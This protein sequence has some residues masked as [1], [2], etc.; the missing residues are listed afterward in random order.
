MNTTTTFDPP[1]SWFTTATAWLDERGKLAWIAAM[2]LGFVFLWPVGLAILFYMIWSKRMFG[3]H[4]CRDRQFRKRGFAWT[5]ATGNSA[6]DRYRDDT[7]KRLMD[8]QAA[9]VAFLER[10][11]NAKDQ[12]EFD[13]FMEER[14]RDVT[15]GNDA[16]DD[17]NVVD[18]KPS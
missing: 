15:G 11:R 18:V 10:L 4:S 2:I 3:H 5:P 9:F 7:I 13:M 17:G 14:H 16:D 6:F 12:T 8:E 1:S